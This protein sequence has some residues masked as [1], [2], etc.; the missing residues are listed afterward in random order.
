MYNKWLKN[1]SKN[2][3]Y[4]S[5]NKSTVVDGSFMR[6]LLFHRSGFVYKREF[7]IKKASKKVVI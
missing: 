6:Y 3:F 2:E 1:H 7:G 5:P 4:L